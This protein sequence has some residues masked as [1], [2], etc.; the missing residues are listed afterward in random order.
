M[1]YIFRAENDRF[2]RIAL[3]EES[4]RKRRRTNKVNIQMTVLSWFLEF[5]N[6]LVGLV[7]RFNT[8]NP[9]S[10]ANLIVLIVFLDAS[11]NFIVIPSSYL[12]NNE[13]NKTM[14][15]ADGW[16]KMFKGRFISNKV[17]PAPT[18][19]ENIDAPSCLQPPPICTISGNLSALDGRQNDTFNQKI[20]TDMMELTANIMFLNP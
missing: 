16:Y 5:I 14:I 20:H 17:A 4:R 1:F 7:I 12:F 19:A 10:D 3:S 11:I 8:T 9:Y 15:I 13:V 6:G 2:L 18:N